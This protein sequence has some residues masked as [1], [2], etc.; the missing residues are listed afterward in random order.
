MPP[1][2]TQVTLGLP[3]QAQEHGLHTIGTSID[4][5]QVS[6][7]QVLTGRGNFPTT[8][9]PGLTTAN[10]PQVAPLEFSEVMTD[11]RFNNTLSGISLQLQSSRRHSLGHQEGSN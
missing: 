10:H 2:M 1:G 4:W 11:Q 8:I 7:V 9:W 6:Q 3:D 5:E